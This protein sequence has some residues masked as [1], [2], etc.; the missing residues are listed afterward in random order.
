MAS[1]SHIGEV[2]TKVIQ[3]ASAQPDAVTSD[4]LKTAIKEAK[5]DRGTDWF[6][7]YGTSPVQAWYLAG[8]N[9]SGGLSTMTLAA[10]TIIALPRV[11]GKG[12]RLAS[13]AF[14]QTGGAAAGRKARMAVFANTSDS[15]LYP[16]ELVVDFGEQ[17]C[18]AT[19][20][21][22]VLSNLVLKE[23]TLYWWA[24]VGN[25]ANI[26]IRSMVR[27]DVLAIYGLDSGFGTDP[28]W[29]LNVS[30][31]YAAFPQNFPGGASISTAADVPALGYRFDG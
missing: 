31:T 29:G 13:V 30:F 7:Q 10:D 14:R 21:K 26:V 19:G 27:D 1:E 23:D 2:E 15:E 4:E 18:S 12:G 22:S 8:H 25:N 16:R 24:I 28:G 20:V 6:Q 3:V 9:G 5:R 11:A 17:D